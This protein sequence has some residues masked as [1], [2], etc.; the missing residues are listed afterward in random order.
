MTDLLN[1]H[2]D[3]MLNG[4]G[5]VPVSFTHWSGSALFDQSDQ[6][7]QDATGDELLVH[8]AILRLQ[9]SEHVDDFGN[10]LVA[11]GDSVTISGTDYRVSDVRDGGQGAI[12]GRELHV[13]VVKV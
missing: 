7:R 1:T 4:F 12:D 11:R 3:Y 9:R 10:K 13:W 5:S 2:L 6:V 8:E